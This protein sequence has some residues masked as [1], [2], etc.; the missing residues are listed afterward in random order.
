NE[1]FSRP[2]YEILEKDYNTVA[3]MSKEEISAKAADK[4]LSDKLEVKPGDPVL[5]RKR[6][7]FD[8]GNRPIEWNVG[9]Y[10][11]DSFVYTVESERTL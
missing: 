10:R 8:P 2:L 1:D 3:L 7:V 6:F 9:Y 5:K 4:L 11:A